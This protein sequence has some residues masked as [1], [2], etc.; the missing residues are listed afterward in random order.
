MEEQN[1]TVEGFFLN[2]E[3]VEI[4]QDI[5]INEKPVSNSKENA[6]VF[7]NCKARNDV[8]KNRHTILGYIKERKYHYIDNLSIYI[9]P[10]LREVV[11]NI[12]SEDL[13]RLSQKE[14][15]AV[16]NIIKK[17]LADIYIREFVY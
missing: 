13:I 15:D 4:S 8:N 1:K 9:F 10:E 7:Y 3:V 6:K 2:C 17:R 12:S 16:L 14:D 5:V 11:V